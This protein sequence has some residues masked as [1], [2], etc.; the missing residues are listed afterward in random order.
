MD[1]GTEML[2]LLR[3]RRQGFSLPQPFYVDADFFRAD[4]EMIWRRDWLFVGHDCELDKP[5]AF[6]TVQ[7]GDYPVNR[8]VRGSRAA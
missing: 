6:F 1:A 3:G 5:G 7:V 8:L 2:G 4:M